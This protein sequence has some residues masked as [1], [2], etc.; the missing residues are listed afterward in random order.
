MVGL[1]KTKEV[2]GEGDLGHSERL[3]PV[4]VGRHLVE[5]GG[6]VAF[7]VGPEMEVVVEHGA[8]GPGLATGLG[9]GAGV[10]RPADEGDPVAHGQLHAHHPVVG[11]HGVVEGTQAS[12]SDDRSLWLTT[13]PLHRVLSAAMRPPG[14]NLARTA[15]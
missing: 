4:A 8:P 14:A 11:H 13:L 2:L 5:R 10:G 3:G 1:T 9:A 6:R 12:V 15:S 7:T